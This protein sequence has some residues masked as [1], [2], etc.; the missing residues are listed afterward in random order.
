M[1][2][3]DLAHALALAGLRWSPASGDRFAIDAEELS[4]ALFT[5][6]DMTIEVHDHPSGTVLGFNGTTEWALDSVTLD[7]ALWYPSEEQL[8][9]L[10]GGAFR[11]LRRVEGEPPRYAVEIVVHGE[12]LVVDDEVPAQAYAR[13]LH[14]L[15]SASDSTS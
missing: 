13:A 11:A 3:H 12:A 14:A 8:R 2:S 10:L 9:T 4:D 5:V 6:S 7:Q 15:I 1:I